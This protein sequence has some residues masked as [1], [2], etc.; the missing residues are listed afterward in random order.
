VHYAVI[1]DYKLVLVSLLCCCSCIQGR[2][3]YTKWLQWYS[4]LA[5]WRHV[6]VQPR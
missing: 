5:L 6:P 3:V 1:I 4:W 2:V